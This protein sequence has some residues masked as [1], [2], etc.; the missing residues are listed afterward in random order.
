MSLTDVGAG[1]VAAVAS[2]LIAPLGPAATPQPLPW[3]AAPA[4][5]SA[6]VE[7]DFAARYPLLLVTLL[8]DLDAGSLVVTPTLLPAS[9][10][11]V[12]QSALEFAPYTQ[13][14]SPLPAYIAPVDAGGVAAPFGL[15]VKAVHVTADGTTSGS[16]STAELESMVRI[17]LVQGL[18][19]RVLAVMLAEKPRLR[20]TARQITAIRALA[21]A[22]GDA[23]D[24][25]GADLRC[26]RFADQLV[27]DAGRKSPGTQPLSPPGTLEDDAS[28]RSRLRVLRGVRLPSPTWIDEVMNGPGGPASAGSG[29]LAD[30]GMSQ[31]VEVDESANELHLAFR[32]VAPGSAHGRANLLDAIRRVHLVWPA[33]SVAGDA[34]HDARMVPQVVFDRAAQARAALAQWQ[35]PA[36]QPVAPSLARA[37]ELL[38]ERCLQLGARPW[39]ALL[40]GQSDAGGSRFE[41]GLG[42][43]LAPAVAA[44]LD[45][46]VKAATQLGDPTLVP[47]PRAADPFGRWLLTACGLRTAEL[48]PDGTVFVSAVPMGPLIVDLTPSPDSPVP[49]T[50]TAHL[51]AS[52][53][54]AHDAPM[55]DVVNALATSQL[56]PAP[57]A[58]TVLAGLKPTSSV[59]GLPAVVTGLSLPVVTGVPSFVQQLQSVSVRDFAIFDLGPTRTSAAL[60]NPSSLAGLLTLAANAGASSVVPVVTAAG[61]LALIFGVVGL[62]LA[63][64]NLAARQTVLY[65]WEVRGLAGDPVQVAPRR[66][67]AVQVIWPGDGISIVSCL[68]H[69]RS[70]GNDPYEW[71]P[72]L[73][74]STRLSLRQYEHLMNIVELVTPVGVRADTWA[75]RHQHI[76]VDGSGTAV[77]LSPA[78]ARTYRHYRTVR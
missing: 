21:T 8:A 39:P 72:G 31:R 25:I 22:G 33:G 57:T 14:G 54:A 18:L 46:A 68:V 34:A 44:Q 30:V 51:Q 71:R 74:D 28:Y 36:A 77:A 67:P 16:L 64:S 78:A 42:G 60:T 47:V 3:I 61:T 37:L 66:G 10:A 29:W 7:L 35:L 49:L 63:G 12:D 4:P 70:S 41:L 45:A 17:D 73:P 76:D 20:R 24:R 43:Q 65:R 11:P 9:A 6:K 19:G 59:A 40:A 55:V 32:L 75:I 69:I 13:A 52:T 53:D 48:N 56:A 23:L 2:E 62:P 58:A 38:N 15:S 1:S 26:A 5:G 27:W 50:L